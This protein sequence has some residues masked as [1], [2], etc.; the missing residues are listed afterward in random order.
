MASLNRN[1]KVAFLECGR[2]YTRKDASTQS[3]HITNHIK[4][5]PYSCQSN[6]ELC[7]EQSRNTLHDKVKLLYFQ[8][9]HRRKYFEQ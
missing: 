9:K 5:K 4:R 8:K 1:E 6:V 2:E 7:A 3:N